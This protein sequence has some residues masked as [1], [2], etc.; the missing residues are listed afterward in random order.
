VSGLCLLLVG[1]LAPLSIV[2]MWVH[3]QVSD[4]DRYVE[5]VA[6]LA[7]ER[8]IQ[9]VIIDRLTIRITDLLNV[10]AVTQ[11]AIDALAARGLPAGPAANLSALTPALAQGVE[12]SSTTR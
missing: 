12:G 9:D 2:A 4:T 10:E 7:K 8:A 5:T 1:V 3:D 11:E 6:P